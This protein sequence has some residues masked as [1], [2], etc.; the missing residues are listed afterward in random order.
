MIV[1]DK[2]ELKR[3][4]KQEKLN[5]MPDY[6]LSLMPYWIKKP[7]PGAGIDEVSKYNKNLVYHSNVRRIVKL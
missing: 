1:K 5:I 2:N 6:D 3:I 7:K 4:Q